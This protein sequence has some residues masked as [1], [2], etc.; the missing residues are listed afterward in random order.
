MLSKL[1][2]YRN[3]WRDQ[4][5]V[6]VGAGPTSWDYRDLASVPS[7]IVFINDAV[8]VVPHTDN[9]YFFSIHQ[10]KYAAVDDVLWLKWV[11]SIAQPS[12]GV[13]I[14]YVWPRHR[15]RDLWQLDPDFCAAHNRLAVRHGSLSG[16]LPFVW[17]CGAKRILGIGI[18]PET[19]GQ[20]HDPRLPPLEESRIQHMRFLCARQVEDMRFFGLKPRYE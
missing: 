15:R 12:R 19:A 18:N 4:E 3:K 11:G 8:S 10:E 13:A 17:F 9:H 7:P 6:V 20:G 16:V 1:S 5:V 14:N 2:D